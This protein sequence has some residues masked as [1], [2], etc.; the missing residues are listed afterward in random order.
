MRRPCGRGDEEMLLLLLLLLLLL[1][2][3]AGET[4]QED[5]DVEGAGLSS[6]ADEYPL[7][8]EDRA[9]DA[10]G[11]GTRMVNGARFSWC[12]RE[13]PRCVMSL[14][15]R[16][17]STPGTEARQRDTSEAQREYPSLNLSW[18]LGMGLMVSWFLD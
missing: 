2:E 14:V 13:I 4:L 1:T 16:V 11:G 18:S 15:P 3:A 10:W 6:P 7:D 5:D 17:T 8:A 12:V 9:G